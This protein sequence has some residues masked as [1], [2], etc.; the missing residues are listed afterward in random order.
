MHEEMLTYGLKKETTNE[1]LFIDNVPNGLDC[2]CV[3][4][5]CK[6]P[7][8]A[9]N[10]GAKKTH[11]FAHYKGAECGKARMTA[12]HMLAQNILARDKKIM[13]PDYHGDYFQAD[14]ESIEFDEVKLE[15]TLQVSDKKKLRP[16]CIGIKY[17]NNNNAHQLWIE[18]YVTHEVNEEKENYINASANACIEIDLSDLL[19][20]DYSDESISKRLLEFKDDRK[21]ICCPKYD[22]IEAQ[23]KQQAEQEEAERQRIAKEYQLHQEE[24]HRN[25][26]Q[27]VASWFQTKQSDLAETFIRKIKSS[28]F[29]YDVK[30]ADILIP[31]FDFTTYVDEAPKNEDGIRV[32]YTLLN[33]YH[34]KV[35]NTNYSNIKQRLRHF[36]YTQGDI[37]AEEKVKLE[38]LISLRIL[39][40][41]ER[42]KRMF[43]EV[44]I[45][46]V[47]KTCIKKYI[48]EPDIRNAVLMIVSVI[49]H[50]IVGSKA[51]N[52]GELTQ[53]I[54]LQQPSLAKLYLTV[55]ESQ[56]KYPNDYSLEGRDMLAELRQFAKTQKVEAN[57][58]VKNILQDCYD[59]AFEPKIE[60]THYEPYGYNREFAGQNMNDAWAQLNKAFNEQ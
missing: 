20:T 18:I 40:I 22:K 50:H 53:E 7:L 58:H 3:C 14:T 19:D 12:L 36:Q 54:I 33:Y 39:Y 26:Q 16:D 32:F 30:I 13:L 4:P 5:H 35:T 45:D 52:F 46:D 34:N 44:D 38:E 37:S 56:D 48:F 1:L 11:H 23:Q 27:E 29:S 60:Q 59:F 8:I 25:L 9:R 6:H 10:G 28:P 41:L 2:G 31:G 21:W 17:D 51:H 42:N 15:E 43:N 24:I 47:Y 57:E 49:Y 55:I